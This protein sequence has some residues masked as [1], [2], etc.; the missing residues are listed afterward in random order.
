MG[1]TLRLEK[2]H[3]DLIKTFLE[4]HQINYVEVQIEII[5][6]IA[7]KVEDEVQQN[8]Y[9]DVDQLVLYNCGQIEEMEFHKLEYSMKR[10]FDKRVINKLRSIFSSYVIGSKIWI[11]LLVISITFISSNQLTQ[12]SN[13]EYSIRELTA[14][15]SLLSTFV[16]L[17]FYFLIFK[18][19]HY[20]SLMLWRSV[21][22]FCIVTYAYWMVFHYTDTFWHY[23]L[24][25]TGAYLILV[26]V[27]IDVIRWGH[28]WS[29]DNYINYNL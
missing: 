25:G 20:K 23:H 18:A 12:L 22:P 1:H 29:A 16:V 14:A 9:A 2:H 11:T 6:H 13:P 21:L 5:D 8:P 10:N 19:W 28:K 26:F 15:I 4:N 17:V 27:T 7:S 24:I 3:I